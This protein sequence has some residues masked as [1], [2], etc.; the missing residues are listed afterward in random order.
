MAFSL[1]SSVFRVVKQVAGMVGN[2]SFSDIALNILATIPTVIAEF[3]K[4][5]RKQKDGLTV[6]DYKA[7]IDDGL[8]A[9]D[10][11]TGLDGIDVI[12]DLPQDKEEEFLDHIKEASRIMLYNKA[13]VEGFVYND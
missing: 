6:E 1:F 2:Q 12:K 3:T 5:K 13:G 8:L 9:F 7:I 10:E 11:Q 4:F